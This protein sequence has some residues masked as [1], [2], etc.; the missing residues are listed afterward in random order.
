MARALPSMAETRPPSTTHSARSAPIAGQA[1][2]IAADCTDIAE[3]DRLRQQVEAELG[4]V[5]ILAVFVAGG[6]AAPGPTVELTE[7]AWA[8]TINGT[9]S[10]TVVTI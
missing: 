5:D 4:S 6:H 9:L 8:S 1:L 10:A 3:I 2:G 7:E